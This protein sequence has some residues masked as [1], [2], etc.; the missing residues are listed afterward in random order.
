MKLRLIPLFIKWIFVNFFKRIIR[1]NENFR[2]T[3]ARDTA[4]GILAWIVSST[5]IGA[6]VILAS[7]IFVDTANTLG[8]VILTYFCVIL[9]YLGYHGIAIMFNKFIDERQKLFRDLKDY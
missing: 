7:A 6:V 9:A 3:L 2:R 5:L 8:N 1:L 4:H